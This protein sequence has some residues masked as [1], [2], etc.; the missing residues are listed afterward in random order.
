MNIKERIQHSGMLFV[1]LSFMDQEQL[2][3]QKSTI[4]IIN[5]PKF[6]K[7]YLPFQ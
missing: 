1:K 4:V 5:K 7:G 2:S 3:L 6:A